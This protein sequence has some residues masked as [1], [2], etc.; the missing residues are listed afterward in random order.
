MSENIFEI[1]ASVTLK[2]GEGR[3]IKSGGDW[4]YDNEI[5]FVEKSLHFE[6]GGMVRVNDFDGYFMG[7]GFINLNSRIRVRMMKRYDET[8]VDSEYIKNLLTSAWQLRKAVTDISCC[9]IVFGEAD[10]IPGFVADKYEDVIVFESLALGTDRL[11][12][13]ILEELADI[14]SMDGIKINRIFERSNAPV[15]KKEGM[16]PST[17]WYWLR[18]DT[19][20]SWDAGKQMA[21]EHEDYVRTNGDSEDFDPLSHVIIKENGVRYDVDV[22]DGQKTGFFLDQKYNRLSVQNLVRR[23][24]DNGL[25]GMSVLD[26]FTH[27]GTFA[28]N[29]ALGGADFVT[30]VD[31]SELAI[32][33]ARKNAELNNLSDRTEFVTAD[34]LD[35]L[36]SLIDMGRSYDMVILDPPAFTKSR[37]ATRH[38]I[39]GYREINTRGMKLVK[40]GGYLA[41]ASCS[42][43]MTRD[44]FEK[45]IYESAR[46]SHVTLQR[47]EFRQQAPDHPVKVCAD[48]NSDYL[49]FY[50]FRVLRA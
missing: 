28:L 6:N 35:Y 26:C 2:K 7:Y 21:T 9:R 34:V 22:R 47:L 29:A 8:P 45:V 46:A 15:R 3:T 19:N 4:I 43:F 27:M 33:Q 16:V 40:T 42:H 5:D 32:R 1:L 12:D 17:G 39:N 41:T 49:K 44:L 31:I 11:K 30:G 48:E 37:T 10:G 24:T 23:L 18:P 36:P 50:I 25:R 20:P 38:A 14:L 13:I